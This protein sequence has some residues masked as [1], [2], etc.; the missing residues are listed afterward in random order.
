[1]R[2]PTMSMNAVAMSTTSFAAEDF[3]GA[4][5]AVICVALDEHRR[6]AGGEEAGDAPPDQCLDAEPRQCGARIRRQGADAADLDPDRRDVREAAEC[7]CQD[8]LCAD[9]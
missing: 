8:D 2:T 5:G 7:V 3:A 6:D 4:P 1:M 9:I